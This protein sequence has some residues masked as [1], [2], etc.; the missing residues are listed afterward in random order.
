MALPGLFVVRYSEIGLKGK[1][2]SFF[3]ERLVRNLR[4]ATR[5][6][7][8]E[9]VER[10]R[11][12]V[13]I[14]HAGC[15]RRIAERISD[16]PGVRSFSVARP[17]AR[18]AAAIEAAAVALA[19]ERLAREPRPRTFGVRT[20]RAD[21]TFPLRSTEVSAKVGAAVLAALPDLVVRLDEP[22]LDIAIEIYRDRAFVMADWHRGPGGLPVGTGGRVVLL[23]SGGIDSPVA[24]WLL[25]KRGCQIAP[26][27]CHAF[28]FTGDAAKEKVID[29]ARALAQRQSPLD[30]RVASITE[31]QVAMRD[32][33]KP[34][35][36]VVLY[37]RLMVRIAERVA[38][39]V[40]APAIATGENLGQV[41]SQTLTNMA[42]IDQAARR[43]ILRPLTTY[44]KEETIELA[45][46]MG[47]FEISIRPAED[48]CQLFLPKSPATHARL[49][50][51]LAEEA[52]LDVEGL[53]RAAADR[54][55]VVRFREGKRV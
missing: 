22:D 32:A 30:L 26:V 42:V 9:R 41:A 21:K 12:R 44:D 28:P 54:A 11:G 3:E 38:A 15:E 23:L 55:E 24:G 45:R 17:V 1:N 14:E 13:L 40:G 2:R 6:L 27:Y 53:A 49:D 39:R 19:S 34:E 5:G 16:T 31:A 33:C 20:D 46:R 8:V 7:G 51:V 29:L 52:R 43:P 18:D 36:L 48:C 25:Q 4:E 50:E 35:L 47:T 37:R 10:I